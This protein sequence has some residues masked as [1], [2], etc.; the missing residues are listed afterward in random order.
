MAK[1]VA[2]IPSGLSIT[3]SHKI[4]KKLFKLKYMKFAQRLTSFRLWTMR[5]K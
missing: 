2:H 1:L 3:S 5:W 4:K